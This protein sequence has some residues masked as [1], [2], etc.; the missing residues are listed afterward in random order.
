MSSAN[1]TGPERR[2][3]PMRDTIVTAL[4]LAGS[5]IAIYWLGIGW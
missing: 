1:Y 3:S 2:S 4:L 5:F